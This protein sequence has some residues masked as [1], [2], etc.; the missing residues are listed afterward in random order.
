MS[1]PN[2][3]NGKA[4]AAFP[5]LLGI[6]HVASP[7]ALHAAEDDN[8]HQVAAATD[9]AQRAISKPGA[10]IDSG[11]P[12]IGTPSEVSSETDVRPILKAHCTHCH[13]EE[14]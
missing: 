4:F 11:K 12:P 5:A 10:A 7:G 3:A 1:R 6:L 9:N 8:A 2:C 14:E 13:G